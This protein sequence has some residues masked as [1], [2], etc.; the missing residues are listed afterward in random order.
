MEAKS[1]NT[2]SKVVGDDDV[3]LLAGLPRETFHVVSAP[4]RLHILVVGGVQQSASSFQRMPLSMTLVFST[5]HETLLRRLRGA[6]R[7]PPAPRE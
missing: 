5:E 1:D 6:A 7:T 3:R 4:A 2:S